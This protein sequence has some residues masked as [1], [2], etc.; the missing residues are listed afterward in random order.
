MIKRLL[1]LLFLFFISHQLLLAGTTGKISGNVK[2]A[3]TGEPLPGI[4]II[5]EGTTMG[6]ASDIDGN[7]VINN[8]SPGTYVVVASGVGLQ[9]KRFVD[10]KIVADFTTSLDFEMSTESIEVE[11]VVVSGQAQRG[12]AA[13]RRLQRQQDVSQPAV[14]VCDHHRFGIAL[15]PVAARPTPGGDREIHQVGTT[16]LDVQVHA[17]PGWV[18]GV[19]HDR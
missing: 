16:L 18:A 17:D 2:D 3:D 15:D 4:N 1:H 6:A 10:V 19:E 8:I 7:F 11:T 12:P 5:I 9:S 13:R 14:G